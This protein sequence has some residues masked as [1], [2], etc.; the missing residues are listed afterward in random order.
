MVHV[1]MVYDDVCVH[2]YIKLSV[3]LHMSTVL[4]GGFHSKYHN[5]LTRWKV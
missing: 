3:H 1:C 4:V 5:F 2:V